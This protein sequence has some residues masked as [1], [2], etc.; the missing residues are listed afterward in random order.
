MIKRSDAKAF[1]LEEEL[2]E[3]EDNNLLEIPKEFISK[4]N[5]AELERRAKESN[6]DDLLEIPSIVAGRKLSKQ[7]PESWRFN[8][9]PYQPCGWTSEKQTEGFNPRGESVNYV[10]V[11]DKAFKQP[12]STITVSGFNGEKYYMGLNEESEE[13]TVNHPNHYGGD[14]VYEAIKVIEAWELG[15]CLG[16]TVKYISRAGK[17]DK[18]KEIEDIRKALWYLQR[19]LDNL[20]KV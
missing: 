1:G 10:W 20:E 15:F 16:N 14:T 3:M 19:H 5:Q 11:D 4:M 17:K 6:D 12:E 13:E 8:D 7:S 18:T 2:S 9:R